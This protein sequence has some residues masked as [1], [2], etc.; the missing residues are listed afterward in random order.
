MAVWKRETAKKKEKEARGLPIAPVAFIAVVVIIAVV[1]LTAQ[2]PQAQ[3]LPTLTVTTSAQPGEVGFHEVYVSSDQPL[4]EIAVTVDGKPAALKKQEGNAYTFE[5]FASPYEPIGVKP[6][7]VNALDT[8]G[9]A[10]RDEG[11]GFYVGYNAVGD[12]IVDIVYYTYERGGYSPAEMAKRII[13][14][15]N[16]SLNLFYELV[17]EGGHNTAS[18]NALVPLIQNL[19]Y[20]SG[21]QEKHFNQYL[22]TVKG[23]DWVQCQDNLTNLMPLADCERILREENSVIVRYPYYPSAQVLV[24]NNTIEL[25]PAP[26]TQGYLAESVER[27]I[28][29]VFAQAA[30]A[31]SLKGNSTAL[32]QTSQ[33]KQ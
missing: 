3:A 2:P 17:A 24:T 5:F 14:E 18:I 6:I 8:T 20:V 23:R 19:S 13:F 10:V 4:R 9:R 15:D 11:K 21:I 27:I 26:A 1:L 7:V 28:T 22:V 25:Q 29:E 12:K 16:K 33:P 32:N 30:Q 31:I